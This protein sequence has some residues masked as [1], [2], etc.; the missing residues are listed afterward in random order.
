[1]P[2]TIVRFAPEGLS[3]AEVNK[4]L[5]TDRES[6]SYQIQ[7]FHVSGL[8][9]LPRDMLSL[10]GVKWEDRVL[11]NW[12]NEESLF[13]V[14][15]VLHIK[16]ADGRDLRLSESIVIDHYLAKQ[17][18]LLGDNEWEELQIKTFYSSSLYLRERLTMRVTWNY[19]EVQEKGWDNFFKNHLPLW[20]DSHT[21]HLKDNGSNGHYVGDKLSLADLETANVIDHFACLDRG[22][23]IVKQIKEGSP[24]IWKVKE[25]VDSEPRLQ[26]WRQSEGYK[27]HIANSKAMYANTGM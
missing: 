7:Y 19:K 12:P 23:Q 17:F 14:F 22:D 26:E 20:I 5:T 21:K 10:G 11:T 24:E 6:A 18:G 8:G 9:A 3:T 4:S 27:E 15:P 16:T 13:G 25:L 1:M 2:M